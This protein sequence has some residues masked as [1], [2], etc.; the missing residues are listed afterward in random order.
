MRHF[1]PAVLATW[2]LIGVGIPN[3]LG[4]TEF[5][6]AFVEKYAGDGADE[7]FKKLVRK[8]G[9]NV[10]HVP[11][12]PKNVHNAYGQQLKKLITGEVKERLK[13]AVEDGRRKEEVQA[14]LAELAKALPA[15][16]AM[17]NEA[18]E[19]YGERIES[20]RLPVELP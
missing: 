20:G 2:L 18:G 13:K 15:V 14:L 8:T 11:R 16:A 6:K 10:C 17:K 5:R 4:I 19:T 3:V 1:G 7:D 9:C 12:K